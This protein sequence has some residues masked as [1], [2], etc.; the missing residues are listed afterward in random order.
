MPDAAGG[1][2][3]EPTARAEAVA[4]RVELRRVGRLLNDPVR[5]VHPARG[6][7]GPETLDALRRAGDAV[8]R[9]LG[10]WP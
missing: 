10:R 4:R 6:R 8:S 3:P 1:A 7:P 2:A 5:A 9:E